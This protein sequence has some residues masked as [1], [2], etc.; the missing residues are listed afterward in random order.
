MQRV[1]LQ[2]VWTE[3]CVGRVCIQ[4]HYNDKNT[5]SVFFLIY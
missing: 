2:V 3:M 4:P 1:P 5:A